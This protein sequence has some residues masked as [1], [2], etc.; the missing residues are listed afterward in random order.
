MYYFSMAQF[1]ATE[2]QLIQNLNLKLIVKAKKA[3]NFA[4]ATELKV[5]LISGKPGMKIKIKNDV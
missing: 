1:A 5:R 4:Y 2:L 3:S